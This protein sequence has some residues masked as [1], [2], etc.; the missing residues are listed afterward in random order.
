M[1]DPEPASRPHLVLIAND[2]EWSAR[3]LESILAPNGYAVLRA[4]TG[5]QAL[6]RARAARPDLVILD[7]QMP[8]LHGIEVC[9]TLRQDPR[10]SATT[11]ILI[12]TAGPSG[13]T[14]R[15]E[16]YRA[17]AWEFLGQPLD[18]ESLLLKLETFLA[19][20][21][22]ADRFREDALLDEATGLY[23]MRG[24]SR[25]AR[26]VASEAIR[27]H[28]P[29]VCLAL[30]HDPSGNGA[31]ADGSAEIVRLGQLL[32]EHGRASDV[33]GRLGDFEFAVI[34]PATS[35]AGAHQLVQ[36]LQDAFAQGGEAG[37]A[38]RVRAGYCAVPDFAAADVD[39]IEML[40]RAT[41]ALRYLRAGDRA[42][43]VLSFEQVPAA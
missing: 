8:D 13:R 20:K 11:P 27:R 32:R 26:E 1:T 5:Q 33:L 7:A 18:G 38:L 12:T 6:E 29:L 24:L 25:R 10:F 34:A 4:Y 31:S 17:G 40:V 37:S 9:R 3:S 43:Q 35:E 28:Q 42:D 19:A 30:A 2:Q 15:L 41:A 39:A 36:R 21:L 23:N 22:E 14:Q 16:A